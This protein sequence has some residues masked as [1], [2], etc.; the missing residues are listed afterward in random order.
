MSI[1]TSVAAGLA[2]AGGIGA[3]GS[4][5]GSLIGAHAT[6]SA[7]SKQE[8][9]EEQALQFQEQEYADQKANQSPYIGAGQSA[10]SDLM[11]AISS[12]K[13]GPGAIAPFTAPTAADAQATPG[14][15][16]TQNQGEQGIER[17]AAAAGGA[18][19][20]GTL[21]SLASFDSGLA[22]STYQQTYGNALNTYQANLAAMNQGFNQLSSIAGLGENAAANAGNTGAQASSTIGNTL[23]SIGSTEA[24]GTLGVANSITGGI[25]GVTGA[26]STP[27]YLN[28]LAQNQ[29]G[30]ANAPLPSFSNGMASVNASMAPDLLSPTPTP[31]IIPD[32]INV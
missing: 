12:G 20:G 1:G 8:T 19:T 31:V 28:Y 14:Y 23:S 26:L 10:L 5:G 11:A 7:A 18:F 22:D 15:Q 32:D 4:I 13:Y 29:F 27:F 3:A 17:G 9:A 24:S 16:F 2:I 25:N 30:G 6:S 21:K